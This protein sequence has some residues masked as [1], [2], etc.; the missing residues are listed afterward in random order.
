MND[1][2][3][4]LL[5]ERF[6]GKIDVCDWSVKC[7]ENDFDSKSLRILASMSKWDSASELDDYFQRSLKELGWDK[8]NK[9]DYL[10]Q[11]ARIIAQEI[12][13]DKTDPI[14]ASRD[15]Y[16][17]LRDLDYPSELHGWYE[18]DEMIWDFEYF[19]KTGEQGYW[20]R[21]KEQLISEIK[22][23]SEELLQQKEV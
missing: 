11:Y 21:P 1:E 20:F 15:I 8:I 12:V 14:K 19:L 23:V 18:I 10:M 3:A 9:E 16:Q 6:L 7:L 22:K 13:E 2:A 4:K 5:A 17:I